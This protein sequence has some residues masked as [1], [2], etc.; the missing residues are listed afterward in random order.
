MSLPARLPR[1]RR[2]AP[3]YGLPP[4]YAAAPP[5]GGEFLE[6]VRKLWRHRWAIALCTLV[7]AIAV[8]AI[9]VAMP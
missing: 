8:G 6:T 9:T 4:P 5:P 7:G 3:V 2:P 1:E